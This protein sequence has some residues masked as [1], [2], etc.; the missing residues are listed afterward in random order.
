MFM[1]GDS[2]P[3]STRCAVACIPMSCICECLA[4]AMQLGCYAPI[5][6]YSTQL[7]D[8]DFRVFEGPQGLNDC[9]YLLKRCVLAILL[10]LSSIIHALCL[11]LCT[12]VPE[13][14]PT[15]CL[16]SYIHGW[17]E[18]INVGRGAV[19]AAAR[20]A[21]AGDSHATPIVPGLPHGHLSVARRA[22]A[23]RPC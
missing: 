16:Y 20:R 22:R 17:R 11:G 6:C 13:S 14:W 10:L 3:I 8:R 4:G 5:L 18:V 7:D 2:P 23:A 12:A 19:A 9:Q 15:C 1:C 21:S